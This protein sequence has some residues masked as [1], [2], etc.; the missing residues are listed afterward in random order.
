M[1]VNRS[2]TDV[3]QPYPSDHVITAV[4]EMELTE[5]RKSVVT[6]LVVT[7]SYQYCDSNGSVEAWHEAIIRLAKRY[8]DKGC[9]LLQA[10]LLVEH[11]EWS[12]YHG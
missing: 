3:L 1:I 4:L 8:K 2:I 9:G 6:L 7:I 10:R 11:A 5:C 12:L